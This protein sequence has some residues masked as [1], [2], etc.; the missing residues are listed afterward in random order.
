MRKVCLAATLLLL[1]TTAS[2]APKTI[3]RFRGFAVA[4]GN[5]ATGAKSSIDIGIYRWSTEEEAEQFRKILRE[6]GP[7]AL[8]EALSHSEQVAF[9]SARGN[10][11]Y[12]LRYA[13]E[14]LTSDGKRHILLAADRPIR[15][16]E[17]SRSSRSGDYDI[18]LVELILDEKGKGEGKIAL[19]VQMA[20][21]EANNRLAIETYSSE[22]VRIINLTRLK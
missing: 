14:G 18:S 12:Q 22:P 1:T 3:E 19:G 8:N 6:Q 4:M 5:V 17:M 2:S 21:D 13:R 7:K 15:F 20:W 11:G 9:L 16:G 10:L